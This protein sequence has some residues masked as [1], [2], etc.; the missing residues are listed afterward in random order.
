MNYASGLIELNRFQTLPFDC[1]YLPGE[2]ERL[3]YRFVAIISADAYAHLLARGWRRF[4]RALFRP[5]CPSCAKC[6]SLRVLVSQFH[7][8]ESQR[9]NLRHNQ[10]LELIVQAPTLTSDHLRVYNNYR[11]DMH[12]RRGWPVDPMTDTEYR[13]TY[14][15]NPGD[16]AREFLFFDKSKLVGVGLA[17]VLPG[18]L[19][20]ISF[21]HDPAYRRDA[22]G[23]FAVLKQLQFARDHGLT[24][25]YL[26]YWISECQSMAYKNQYRPHEI[27]Q[28]FPADH[29]EP[30]WLA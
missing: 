29:E 27:L 18:S 11:L 12:A 1:S 2:T 22:L 17:D 21:F 26:G 8:S 19:S 16:F 28:R 6:R 14:V 20:S 10:D 25:H 3:D 24:H 4:G 5:V 7:P 30:V 9:R 15:D 13:R 23:V